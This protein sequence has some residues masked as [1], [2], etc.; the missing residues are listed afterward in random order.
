MHSGIRLR[1][2]GQEICEVVD[3][4]STD[5]DELS[6]PRPPVDFDQDMLHAMRYYLVSQLH[7]RER[8]VAE[9]NDGR[10]MVDAVFHF[11]AVLVTE[12][13]DCFVVQG[14]KAFSTHKCMCPASQGEGE[15]KNSDPD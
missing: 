5:E 11:D 13:A 4:I 12:L 9:I 14:I 1:N 10:L 3:V 8:C 6:P 7:S 2:S 15:S